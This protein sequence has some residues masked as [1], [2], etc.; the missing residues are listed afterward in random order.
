MSGYKR[1]PP[2][3]KQTRRIPPISLYTSDFIYIGVYPLKA[4]F[5]FNKF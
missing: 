4:A 2:F 3:I 5:V 1:R